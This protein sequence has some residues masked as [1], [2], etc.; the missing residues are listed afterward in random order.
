MGPEQ[1][2]GCGLPGVVFVAGQRVVRLPSQLQGATHVLIWP[3][4]AA[5]AGKVAC[6][7]PIVVRSTVKQRRKGLHVF[8]DF[9]QYKKS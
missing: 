3:W 9:N 5:V 7:T 2:T 8:R 4:D 1:L 6:D